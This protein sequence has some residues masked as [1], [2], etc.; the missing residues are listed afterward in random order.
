M[1]NCGHWSQQY[2]D[3]PYDITDWEQLKYACCGDHECLWNHFRYVYWDN[4]KL[5]EYMIP[6]DDT[7]RS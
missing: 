4:I 7:V 3:A 1:K 2:I 6:P 5:P